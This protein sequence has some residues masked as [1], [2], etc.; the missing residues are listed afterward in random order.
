M[1]QIETISKPFLN[2]NVE[3]AVKNLAQRHSILGIADPTTEH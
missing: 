3:N 1:D 2:T